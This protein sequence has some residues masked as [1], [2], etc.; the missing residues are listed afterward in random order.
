MYG[1]EEHDVVDRQAARF[2]VHEDGE[3]EAEY[4]VHLA[5]G[6]HRLAHGKADVLELH[7]AVVEAIDRLEDRPLGVGPVRCGG[8]ELL[9]DQALGIGRDALA[10]AADDSS[11]PR[12]RI[13]IKARLGSCSCGVYWPCSTRRT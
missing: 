10:L 13:A 9:A 3:R 4:C 5:G 2:Q 7:A 12:P 8:A 6:Q 1:S 11:G